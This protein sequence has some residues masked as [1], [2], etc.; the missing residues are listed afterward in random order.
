MFV[1]PLTLTHCVSPVKM[2]GHGVFPP[3]VLVRS[4]AEEAKSA[5]K[6]SATRANAVLPPPGKLGR[7]RYQIGYIVEP[8][9]DSVVYMG[10]VRF[11]LKQ[12][13]YSQLLGQLHL[14]V[15]SLGKAW[16]RLFCPR[17]NSMENLPDAVFGPYILF[18]TWIHVPFLKYVLLNSF[19]E[20]NSHLLAPHFIAIRIF[21]TNPSRK[22]D[23]C[24]LVIACV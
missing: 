14:R 12:N 9:S 7:K 15:L 16:E 19:L 17:I 22:N 3:K 20:T 6:G 2:E 5:P 1:Q 18:V 13:S 4:C 23:V 24:T 11:F 8:F 21:C 10:G